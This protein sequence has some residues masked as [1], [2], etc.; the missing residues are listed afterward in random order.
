MANQ[1]LP[2]L[3]GACIT[4]NASAWNFGDRTQVQKDFQEFVATVEKLEGKGGTDGNGTHAQTVVVGATEIIR[5]MLAYQVPATYAE[6]LLFNYGLFTS[7]S[8]AQSYFDLHPGMRLRLDYEFCQFASL[9]QNPLV[10][11]Y[12]SAGTASFEVI[13][14]PTGVDGA[15]QLGLNSY[16]SSVTL[17]QVAVGQ[18]GAGGIIDVQGQA[19]RRRHLRICLPTQFP[20]ADS[21]GF[22]GIQQNVTLLAADDI[23]TLNSAS[24]AYYGN[25]PMP[26]GV[27][28]SY[29]R[30]RVMIT[31]EIPVFVCGTPLWVPLTTTLRQLVQQFTTFPRLPNL[32]PQN[33]LNVFKRYIPSISIPGGLAPNAFSSL[34]IQPWSGSGGYDGYDLPVLAAD[35]IKLPVT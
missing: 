7:T 4:I 6:S 35:S 17:P 22:V 1:T 20:S 34:L 28:A 27:V 10:N 21:P 31:P 23:A 5:R 11:G 19:V 15:P 26:S 18:G 9:A 30:G 32:N 33:F 3:R 25:K 8:P 2:Q 13:S 24:D 29:F 14:T 16:L 12:V